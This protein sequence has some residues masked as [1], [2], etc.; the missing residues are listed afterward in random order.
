MTEAEMQGIRSLLWECG[1]IMV[2]FD[3]RTE[4]KKMLFATKDE[5][6]MLRYI[7]SSP[8]FTAEEKERAKDT[9]DWLTKEAA[10]S[11]QSLLQNDD[12][13]VLYRA[14]APEAQTETAKQQGCADLG[15]MVTRSN[16]ANGKSLNT[17]FMSLAPQ[18]TK[19]FCC[20]AAWVKFLKALV[21]SAGHE[22]E[23]RDGGFYFDLFIDQDE[24]TWDEYFGVDEHGG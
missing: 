24:M 22:P 20:K 2:C 16:V 8:V 7:L 10:D 11:G 21:E 12:E 15:C 5:P 9:L 6:T 14:P 13:H 19:A 4:D 17:R 23:I 3:E 18:I 1:E